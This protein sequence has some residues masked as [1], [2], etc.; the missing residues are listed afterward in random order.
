VAVALAWVGVAL[1]TPAL[2]QEVAPA[3]DTDSGPDLAWGPALLPGSAIAGALEAR[4]AAQLVT[5]RRLAE[6]A[7]V[8]DPKS[9]RARALL[10]WFL[11]EGE[12]DLS[13][14]RW[15]LEHAASLFDR[16][17]GTE[18]VD[19]WKLDA[20]VIDQLISVTGAMDDRVA[21]LGWL[22]TFH[23]R[24]TPPRW[25][26][27]GWPLLKLGRFE[28]AREKIDAAL[29]LDDRWEHTHA[30][31]ARCA[32][33]GQLGHRVTFLE[34]CEAE[35]VS[36]LVNGF[37]PA[38]GASNL[39]GARLANLRFDGLDDVARQG[40][41]GSG[42]DA[43]NPW[44]Q[45]MG[46]SLSAGRGV[47]AVER[48]RNMQR[49]RLKLP[50]SMRDQNRAELDAALARLLLVAGEADK[51]MEVVNRA[52]EFPDRL[53]YSSGQTDQLLG[54]TTVLRL[55]MRSAQRER[56]AE[57]APDESWAWRTWRWVRQWLP[58][59]PT[60]RDRAVI[61]GV[62]QSPTRAHGLFRVYLFD[63]LADVPPWLLG[64]VIDSVGT[65]VAQ[66][67]LDAARAD[68]AD[69]ARFTP[70]YDAFGAE[71]AWRAGQRA[72]A[73][74]L[75]GAALLGL[76]REEV[77]LR[78]RVEAVA[79]DAAWWSSDEA[80]ALT[81]WEEA[82]RDDAGVIRRLRTGLPARVVSSGGADADALAARL[83]RSPRLIDSNMGFV[84]A[85]RGSG[86]TLESCL[87]TSAGSRVRCASVADGP[88][89]G[90][91]VARA[92]E[93]FH[94]RVFAMPLGVGTIDWDSLDGTTTVANEAAADRVDALLDG[95]DG[96]SK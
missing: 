65:G 92:A 24:F 50:P 96:R 14:A 94:R 85:V 59:L 91:W 29:A 60:L 15:H 89:E 3:E 74:R 66:A 71:I 41:V 33:E 90:A 54:S 83:R 46:L 84:V 22:D 35:L 8:D 68:D 20:D 93:A 40:T 34:A 78:A 57:R 13:R 45:M 2:A 82:L 17:E 75:A 26:S 12:G 31:N 32:I 47:E 53:G 39:V 63:G 70:Y 5:G 81:L 25:S 80:R 87:L 73:L 10:A 6:Q 43:A 58:D 28:E 49:W 9:V 42:E 86:G 76:P 62:L 11:V 18:G 51:G 23:E 21:Q 48:A 64:E 72:E 52:L 61:R 4:E 69:D 16:G 67:S 7:V 37:D 1:A 88:K 77:L 44:L 56:D 19:A 95:L 30:I 55:A 27:Y 36:E 38:T 79:A